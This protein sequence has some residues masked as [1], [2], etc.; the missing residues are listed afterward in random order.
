MP[1]SHRIAKAFAAHQ[2]AT[3][4]R[5]PGRSNDRAAG[6]LVPLIVDPEPCIV[7]TLRAAGLRQHASEV[8]FP[9][10]K[11]DIGDE[12]LQHTA[13]REANEE[14]G[15]HHV[16]V[17][18]QLTPVPVFTS[19]FFLTPFVGLISQVP[20]IGSPHEVAKVLQLRVLDVLQA[21]FIDAIAFDVLGDTW[22]SPVFHADGYRVYGATAYVLFEVLTVL[23][24]V[25]QV[26]LPERRVGRYS[27]ESVRY[28]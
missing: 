17:L 1:L 23:A 15:L 22:L 10:G 8:S 20:E 19:E 3:M 4:Q 7:L 26:A 18:G 13:L 28:R 12:S 24:E 5:I 6:V 11:P 25:L 9:G 16:Q 27:W 21:D 14:L 2:P